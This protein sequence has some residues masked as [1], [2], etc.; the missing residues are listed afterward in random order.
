MALRIARLED[1]GW[2]E[3]WYRMT[4]ARTL[5]EFKDAMRPMA[6]L[7]GNAMTA[8]VDGNIYYVYNGAI[9]RRDESFDW[10]RPV[11]GSNPAT[12]WQGFLDFAD[13]PQLENP[14]SGWMQNCNGTPFLLSDQDNPRR[15]DYPSYVA[16]ERDTPRAMVSRRLLGAETGWTFDRL[17]AAAFDTRVL[18]AD[19]LL[20][21]WLAA[22]RSGADTRRTAA[23]DSL[24]AW[25]HRSDTASVAMTV[26]AVWAEQLGSGG[27][28]GPALDA[29]LTGLERDFGTWRVRWGELNRTQRWDGFDL[30]GPSDDRA[31]LPLAAVDP[32]LGA[33]FTSWPEPAAGARRWYGTGGGSYVSVVEFG[34]RV[35][36]VA[37]HAFGASGDPASPHYFDQAPLFATGRMRPAW[38][39]LDEIKANEERAYHPGAETAGGAGK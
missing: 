9:P 19:S 4:R 5:A 28:P 39:T 8:D 7:F 17:V 29:A 34:P 20:P 13:L 35:R 18:A 30:T 23:L 37:V 12:E 27:G 2:L 15:A 11:D 25:D 10:S 33:I 24:A 16:T 26:L 6:M 22:A 38:F 14:A 21:R 36:A 3:E 1:D 31:S 32:S